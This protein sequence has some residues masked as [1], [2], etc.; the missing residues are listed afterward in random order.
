[1]G[2]SS[3]S[4]W[5]LSRQSDES[6]HMV[7]AVHITFSFNLVWKRTH[8]PTFARKALTASEAYTKHNIPRTYRGWAHWRCLGLGWQYMVSTLAHSVFATLR[9][10]FPCIAVREAHVE[11]EPRYSFAIFSWSNLCPKTLKA[12]ISPLKLLFTEVFSKFPPNLT[13]FY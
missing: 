12:N 4:A 10:P 13:P 9:A 3:S 5:M 8:C 6:Q 1:M 11:A 2:F 7:Y